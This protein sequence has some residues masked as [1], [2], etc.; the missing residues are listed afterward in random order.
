MS[1][2]PGAPRATEERAVRACV[3]YERWASEERRLSGAIAAIQCPKETPRFD[4][5]EIVLNERLSCFR[6][7]A[8][9]VL[10]GCQEDNGSTR[11]NLEQIAAAVADCPRCSELVELIRARR[12][13][14]KQYGAAKRAVRHAGKLALHDHHHEEPDD[15]R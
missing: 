7:A 12:Y 6:V 1:T 13:A 3:V 8:S 9:E 10:P 11:R 5:E 15:H 2:D 14:R 4:I